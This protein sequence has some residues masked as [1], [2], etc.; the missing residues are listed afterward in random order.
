[1]TRFVLVAL[2]L[3]AGCRSAPEAVEMQ[4]EQAYQAIANNLPRADF[5]W[6][7]PS[8]LAEL[9]AS[10]R[11]DRP[12]EPAPIDLK[13]DERSLKA[14]VEVFRP[15][16]FTIP[17]SS[18]ED[19]SYNYELFPNL[20]FCFVFPFLQMSEARVVFDA[21]KVSGFHAHVLGECDRL[22]AISREVGM[23]GPWE[24]AQAVRRKL[25]ED[26]EEFGEG[27]VSLHFTYATPIPPFIPYTAAARRCAEAFHWA[28][29][30]PNETAK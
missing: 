11:R 14:V 18:I 3:L 15:R 17:Y 28:K 24:H 10:S 7:S 29:T 27:R 12:A 4:P 26:A 16:A 19:V 8:G 1:M 6:G 9:A 5:G 30:H 20:M 13:C 22:E 21:R 25:Q 23:G 2:V